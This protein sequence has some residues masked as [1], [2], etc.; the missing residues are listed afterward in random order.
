MAIH[1]ALEAGHAEVLA[2]DT[3]AIVRR[4]AFARRG[5]LGCFFAAAPA[6]VAAGVEHYQ[7]FVNTAARRGERNDA[8]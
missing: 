7:I 3:D 8:F 4:E 2:L 1:A 5:L 6:P